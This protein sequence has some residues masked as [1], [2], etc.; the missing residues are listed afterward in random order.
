MLRLHDEDRNRG[1]VERETSPEGAPKVRVVLAR[2][3][4]MYSSGSI[5]Y[6][7]AALSPATLYSILAAFLTHVGH[8]QAAQQRAQR[9][10][11]PSISH[12]N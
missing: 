7:S 9:L 12:L 10:P 4:Q 6:G 3:R 8:A 11:P 5:C 1:Q 2:V